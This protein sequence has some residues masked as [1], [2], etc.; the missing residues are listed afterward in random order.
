MN[1]TKVWTLRIHYEAMPSGYRVAASHGRTL[2][3]VREFASL[4]EAIGYLV[5]NAL[6]VQSE[7]VLVA[8]VSGDLKER[9][10]GR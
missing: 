7:L 4:N 2:F 9:E 1:A 8:S 10:A 5:M 3:Q 6:A